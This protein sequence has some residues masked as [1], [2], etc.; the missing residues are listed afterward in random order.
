M[1]TFSERSIVV[2]NRDV[3]EF[4]LYRGD[5]GAIVHCYDENKALEVEFVVADGTTVAVL[6]L[7]P[8]DVR[9]MARHEILHVREVS[10]A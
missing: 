2:L 3:P 6:T 7:A 8:H 4:A 9:P 5:I 10:L 1:N